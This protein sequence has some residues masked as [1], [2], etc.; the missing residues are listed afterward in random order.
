MRS[1]KGLLSVYLFPVPPTPHKK[2]NVSIIN[3]HYTIYPCQVLSKLLMRLL[4]TKIYIRN[5]KTFQLTKTPKL[6]NS[7]TFWVQD[8]TLLY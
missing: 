6:D 1:N 5:P 7:I 2:I 3:T 4:R 8:V